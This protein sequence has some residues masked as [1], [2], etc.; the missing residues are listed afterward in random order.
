MTY[1][2]IH[3]IFFFQYLNCL[4][5]RPKAIEVVNHPLL[6]DS[7]KRISFLHDTSDLIGK[8]TPLKKALKAITLRDIGSNPKG[9][10]VVKWDQ[11]MHRDIINHMRKHSNYNFKRVSDLLR[12][13][14]NM[15][16][17]YKQ[18]PNNIKVR[19]VFFRVSSKFLFNYIN[20]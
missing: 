18:L 17:H 11:A 15:S 2:N 19:N 1:R 8:N 14:R 9:K 6:W 12:F 16:S 10:L 4:I 13:M 7:G 20:N 5:S 3:T